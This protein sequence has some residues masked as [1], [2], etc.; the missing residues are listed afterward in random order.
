MLRLLA[1]LAG[2]VPWAGWAGWEVHGGLFF[3]PGFSKGG[4]APG[5][6][7]AL[8]YWRQLVA[9]YRA[10]NERLLARLAGGET[11]ASGETRSDRSAAE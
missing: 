6:F 11:P 3:P 2:Y 4:L 5:E 7:Q 9:V 10:E 1:V 8:L